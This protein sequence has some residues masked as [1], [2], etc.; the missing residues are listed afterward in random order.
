MHAVAK[1]AE[2]ERATMTPRSNRDPPKTAEVAAVVTL[3]QAPPTSGA[4]A[5]RYAEVVAVVSVHTY[6]PQMPPEK[7]ATVE[8]ASTAEL[9]AE[10][11]AQ[12]GILQQSERMEVLGIPPAVERAEVVAEP[13]HRT[14]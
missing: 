8:R 4:V 11:L 2:A 3:Q 6:P 13:R 1:V 5:N 9:Q 7:P 10:P 14:T 12:A